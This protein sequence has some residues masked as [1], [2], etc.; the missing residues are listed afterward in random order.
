MAAEYSNVAKLFSELANQLRYF[1][2][3]ENQTSNNN[4]ICQAGPNVP[5]S[6]AMHQ[7]DV[8]QP[9][10]QASSASTSSRISTSNT[11]SR[12]HD[13][14]RTLFPHHFTS[15]ARKRR[16]NNQHNRK[17]NKKAVKSLTRKFVC[18]S[19]K[20]QQEVPERDEMRELLVHG[21]GEVK[22]AI[23]EDANEKAIRDK[24]IET[25]PKLKESG[26]FELMYV[27]CRRKDLSVI[28]PGPDGLSMK[29]LATFIAQGKIYVRPGADPAKSVTDAKTG[30]LPRKILKFRTLEMRFPA[31]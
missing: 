23:P 28:P 30:I 25:F 9:A 15:N 27:E 5:N 29:Y 10:N 6:S 2:V 26:G 19:D 18:L 24:L 31:F 22:V 13:E 12:T 11:M 20:D 16:K 7:T 4:S 14:L 21:L 17:N 1:P 3:P 8:A